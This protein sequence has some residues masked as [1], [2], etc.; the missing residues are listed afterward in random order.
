MAS[1]G[2]FAFGRGGVYAV[3]C[4]ELDGRKT[5]GIRCDEVFLRVVSDVDTVL[6]GGVEFF[7]YFLE[8]DRRGLPEFFAQFLGIY[9]ILKVVFDSECL[10]F[11]FLGGQKAVGQHGEDIVLF[12][13]I[14]Y[15]FAGFGQFDG[16]GVV[17]IYGYKLPYHF[18][19]AI[20]AEGLQGLVECCGVVAGAEQGPEAVGYFGG[21]DRSSGSGQGCCELSS[22]TETTF[23]VV[24][25]RVQRI[26]QIKNNCRYHILCSRE[27]GY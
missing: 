24:N 22:G 9:D 4:E 18:L 13:L 10:Y 19:V 11:E 7:E 12:Q 2:V 5:E 8:T 21:C 16:W 26:I 15:L 20:D 23:A 27:S 14:E 1:S 17:S 25:L 6:W 3:L